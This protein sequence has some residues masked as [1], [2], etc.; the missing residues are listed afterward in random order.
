MTTLRELRRADADALLRFRLENRTYFQPFEPRRSEGQFTLKEQRRRIEMA[1]EERRRDEG[2]FFGI[3][4]PSAGGQGATTELV[5]TIAL[6][7]VSRGA[8]Q[9]ATLGYAVAQRHAGR[10]HATQ[11]VQLLLRFAFEQLGLHRV[12]AAVLERNRASIRVLEKSGF[13]FEGVARSYLEIDGVWEDHRTYAITREE[14][15]AP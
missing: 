14:W 15:R 2:Y 8:W 7:N 13:R 6:S 1:A 12:Q 10:G 3:F 11:A 9:N 4:A 5:G